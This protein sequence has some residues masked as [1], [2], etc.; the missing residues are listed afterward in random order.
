MFFFKRSLVPPSS[1]PPHF[2][3]ALPPNSLLQVC[4]TR[5]G[6][7]LAGSTRPVWKSSRAFAPKEG[8]EV[9]GSRAPQDP[10]S[11]SGPQSRGFGPRRTDPRERRLLTEGFGGS[12]WTLWF[13]W[14]PRLHPPGRSESPGR[15]KWL[16]PTRAILGRG[17]FPSSK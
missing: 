3:S 5:M 2:C 10:Q 14:R 7:C 15:A 16:E 9:I 17:R 13:C 1:P 6:Q 8:V 12:E 4:P 11:P